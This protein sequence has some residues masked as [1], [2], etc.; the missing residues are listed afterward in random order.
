MKQNILDALVTLCSLDRG[1]GT[2]DVQN[3]ISLSS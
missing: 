1:C 3:S 2:V